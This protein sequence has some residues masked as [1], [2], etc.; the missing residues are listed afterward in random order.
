M[1]MEFWFVNGDSV[2]TVYVVPEWGRVLIF[3][4]TIDIT[5]PFRFMDKNGLEVHFPEAM[6]D[7]LTKILIRPNLEDMK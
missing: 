5:Q 6:I 2:G 3:D 7:L 1:I 4:G